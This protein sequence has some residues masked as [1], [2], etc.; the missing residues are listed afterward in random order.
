MRMN[1][2]LSIKG[3][4]E[5]SVLL[6]VGEWEWGRGREIERGGGGGDPQ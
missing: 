3:Q 5:R 6:C 4:C 1:A 2:I